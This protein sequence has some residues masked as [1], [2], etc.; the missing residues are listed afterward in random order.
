MTTIAELRAMKMPGANAAISAV[1]SE[2]WPERG[3]QICGT[4]DVGII[5]D[6]D[7]EDVRDASF[8][9]FTWSQFHYCPTAKWGDWVKLA[10]RIM[11]IDAAVTQ[12][13]QVTEDTRH[14]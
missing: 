12:S 5:C 3:L 4:R 10:K 13:P 2:K 14:E 1:P 8:T 7:F 9:S 6:H 11:E